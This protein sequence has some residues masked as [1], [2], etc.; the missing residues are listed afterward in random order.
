M[1]THWLSTEENTLP[2]YATHHISAGAFVLDHNNQVNLNPEH[3]LFRK[4]LI[5]SA[6]APVL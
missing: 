1:L 3:V 4:I 6:I 2:E 5:F